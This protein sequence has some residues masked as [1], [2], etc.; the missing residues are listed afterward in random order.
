[1]AKTGRPS[2]YS[3]L[4]ADAICE[5]LI[6]GRSLLRICSDPD[7]PDESTVYR[8]LEKHADFRD[9]YAR[10]RDQ[11]ADRYAA[12][13]IDLADECR[14]GEIVITRE[15]GKVEKRRSDNVERTRLQIDARKWYASKLAPNKYGERVDVEH[16][17]GLSLTVEHIGAGT[18]PRPAPEE[19]Q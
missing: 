3:E 6:K 2:S 15:D 9:K 13:I 18:Q 5:E 12:E 17:G 1:M 8:W 16:A 10:A 14:P 19:C 7:F 11:Q 4:V